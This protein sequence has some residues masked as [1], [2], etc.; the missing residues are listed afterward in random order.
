MIY[1]VK[2]SSKLILQPTLVPKVCEA[3]L[4]KN[5]NEKNEKKKI[6]HWQ[7]SMLF[8]WKNKCLCFKTWELQI[9]IITVYSLTF[10]TCCFKCHPW[11][12]KIELS[13][14]IWCNLHCTICLYSPSGALQQGTQGGAFARALGLRWPPPRMDDYVSLQKLH[15]CE[16]PLSICQLLCL[17]GIRKCFKMSTS[18]WS[19]FFL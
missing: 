8:S 3:D 12:P 6:G 4:I 15:S 13:H 11:S 7:L 19:F 10:M 2:L 5:S 1:I 9:I 18:S 14:S 17:I 16:N